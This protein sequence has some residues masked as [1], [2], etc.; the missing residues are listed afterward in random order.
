MFNRRKTINLKVGNVGV[1]SDYPVSVQSM[2]NTD[3]K[4][5]K[6]TL[7]QISEL[8]VAG[9]EIVRIAVPDM[10][11]AEKTREIVEGSPIPVIADIHFDYRLAL[12][13]IKNGIHGLRIN[14]GNIGNEERIREVVSAAKEYNIPIRIGV[15]SG[16]VEKEM[17]EKYKGVNSHSLIESALK[18]VQILERLN[19]DKIKI[20]VKA[21]EVPLMIDVYRKLADK[22]DYPLHLGV[23]EAGSI[24]S[25]IVKSAVGIGTLLAEGIGDTIRVS[26]TGNPVKEITVAKDILKSL[27]LRNDGLEIV[28]C[29]TCGRCQVNLEKIVLEVEE[30]TRDYKENI[31]LA[32]M[33]CV[34][35]GPGEAREADLGIAGGIGEGLLFRKGQ[36]IRKVKEED[37]VKEILTELELIRREKNESN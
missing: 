15:N 24:N 10:E 30:K 32:I 12:E 7:L 20:S 9:C 3:T 37:M 18:H 23:T 29:P 35:N 2:T 28:S 31:K 4:N 36:I 34:V 21:S 17:L 13:S 25:G 19:F 26:L 14:P 16:S 11:A 5:P 33:G 22:V 27:K 6:A 1:G 8:A